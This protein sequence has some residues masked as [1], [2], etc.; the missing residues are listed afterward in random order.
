M[1]TLFTAIHLRTGVSRAELTGPTRTR[2]IAYARFI[3][4][5]II[6]ESNPH[7]AFQDV[8]LAMG[9]RDHSTAMYQVKQ[10]RTLAKQDKAFRTMLDQVREDVNN[11]APIASGLTKPD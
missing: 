11:S 1:T 9:G 8:A 2:R 7:W 3:A 4:A 10:A 6:R 5:L